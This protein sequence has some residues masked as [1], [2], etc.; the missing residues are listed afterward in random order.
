MADDQ[1]ENK[2]PPPPPP[3]PVSTQPLVIPTSSPR[4]TLD[5]VILSMNKFMKNIQAKTHSK[6]AAVNQLMALFIPVYSTRNSTSFSIPVSTPFSPNV[7]QPQP[8]PSFSLNPIMS[9]S[10]AASATI[11]STTTSS[12]ATIPTTTTTSSFTNPIP[13]I[14]VPQ[15]P[16]GSNPTVTMQPPFHLPIY[17]QPPPYFVHPFSSTPLPQYNP[18]AM[19]A[20]SF[21]NEVEEYLTLRHIPKYEWVKLVSRLFPVN[22]DTA[23]WWREVTGKYDSW[24]EFRY[25]FTDYAQGGNNQDDLRVIRFRKTQRLD[26]PFESYVWDV[27]ALYRKVNLGSGMDN[28][29]VERVLNSCLPEIAAHLRMSA[30]YDLP[31]LI[32][33][34]R[35]VIPDL[36]NIRRIERKPSELDKKIPLSHLKGKGQTHSLVA[37]IR[38]EI[39]EIGKTIGSQLVLRLT[40][41]SRIIHKQQLIEFHINKLTGVMVMSTQTLTHRHLDLTITQTLTEIG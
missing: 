11:P 2:P 16:G 24:S 32:N 34:A 26:E 5:S 4:V 25:R 20:G 14:G 21:V 19:T 38:P 36:N 7:E 15:T 28:D 37:F 17:Q 3:P 1:Q 18:K 29:I 27:A 31:H 13:S 41:K 10:T 22:S 35:D 30:F 8:G 40:F 12:L 6:T 23:R 39:M 9:Q 33:A